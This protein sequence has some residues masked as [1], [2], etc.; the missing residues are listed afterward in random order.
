MP[1][2]LFQTKS[3]CIH[4]LRPIF[5]LT[6]NGTACAAHYFGAWRFRPLLALLCV[7]AIGEQRPPT[8]GHLWV[9]HG[10]GPGH[11]ISLE[12]P[13]IKRATGFS[14]QLPIVQKNVGHIPRV[15]LS[16]QQGI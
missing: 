13:R 8:M 10:K 14:R 1:T 2:P 7:T 15:Q 12:N 3:S 6:P 5:G 9:M 4:P 16:L 11:L